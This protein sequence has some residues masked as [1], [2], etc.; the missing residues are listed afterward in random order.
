ML[1][2]ENGWSLK[3]KGKRYLWWR[4]AICLEECNIDFFSFDFTR[5]NLS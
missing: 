3:G 5:N 2:S 4:V 1:V